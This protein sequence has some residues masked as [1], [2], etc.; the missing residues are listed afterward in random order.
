MNHEMRM[1]MRLREL[2]GSNPEVFV[3][4]NE[5]GMEKNL[6]FSNLKCYGLKRRRV[7]AFMHESKK[8]L[9]K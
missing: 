3:E 7:K 9:E 5:G 4:R 1:I 2:P 8:Q 6:D